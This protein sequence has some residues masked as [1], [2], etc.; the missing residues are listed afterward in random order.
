MLNLIRNAVDAIPSGGTIIITTYKESC[1]HFDVDTKD[2]KEGMPTLCAVLEVRDNGQGIAEK[3]LPYIFDPFFT[4]KDVGRGSGLGLA[5]VY[6]IVTKHHGTVNVDSTLHTGT[7]V[8][9]SFP[10]L[11]DVQ[12]NYQEKRDGFQP[13]PSA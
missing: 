1:K 5:I 2:T 7:T 8:R 10:L 11:K 3:D 12:K 9:I 4:T 13:D 6:G